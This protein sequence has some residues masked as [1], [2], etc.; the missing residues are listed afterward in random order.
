MHNMNKRERSCKNHLSWRLSHFVSIVRFRF[1]G[2]SYQI[3]IPS[4]CETRI[5]NKSA[6]KFLKQLGTEQ[7]QTSGNNTVGHL[8][9][10]QYMYSIARE[11]RTAVPAELLLDC[12]TILLLSTLQCD[13]LFC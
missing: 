8:A 6:T 11:E 3:L 12:I 1:P 7:R 2:N 4:L 9:L 5:G 13:Y 10:T